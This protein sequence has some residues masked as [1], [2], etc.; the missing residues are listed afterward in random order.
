ME[1]N[2]FFFLKYR[3]KQNSLYINIKKLIIIMK[4]KKI[5]SN[6]YKKLNNDFVSSLQLKNYVLQDTIIDYLE[7]YKINKPK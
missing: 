4:F 6:I 5:N 7:Y 3:A 2:Y 1:I